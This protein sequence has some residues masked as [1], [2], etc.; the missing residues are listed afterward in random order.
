MKTRK[1]DCPYLRNHRYCDYKKHTGDCIYSEC[2]DCPLL[3]DSQSKAKRL[4]LEPNTKLKTTKEI[5]YGL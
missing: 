5:R 4:I 1:H 3:Q 2:S